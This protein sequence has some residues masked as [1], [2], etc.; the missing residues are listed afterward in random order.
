M[1]MKVCRGYWK[2]G[3]DSFNSRQAVLFLGT[4]YVTSYQ[5]NKAG[6]GVMCCLCYMI[7]YET[8]RKHSAY[9]L[10]ISDHYNL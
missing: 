6:Y 7:L 2:T 10:I 4:V 5:Q 8:C 9:P 3:P 1:K